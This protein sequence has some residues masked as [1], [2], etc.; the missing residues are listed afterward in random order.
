MPQKKTKKNNNE[1]VSF[2]LKSSL[3][4]RY[5]NTRTHTS[6]EQNLPPCPT[7]CLVASK[8]N[9]KH[10]MCI[11]PLKPSLSN[12]HKTTRT[13]THIAVSAA[14]PLCLARAGNRE[15]V[16]GYFLCEL[17]F[18]QPICSTK[19]DLRGGKGEA[20]LPENI[21]GALQDSILRPLQSYNNPSIATDGDK[22]CF[23]RFLGCNSIWV[24][25]TVLVL[26]KITTSGKHF[27][28][29]QSNLWSGRK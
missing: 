8:P 21:H 6:C 2:P 27:Q 3:P 15:F 13:H 1:S 26:R 4:N 20:F 19:N 23:N 25:G 5:K 7:H 10:Q 29:N 22:T 12:R 24:H 16:C 28:Q 14:M 9:Q 11:F 17:C 18:Q